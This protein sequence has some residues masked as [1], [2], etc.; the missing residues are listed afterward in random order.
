MRRAEC[1]PL[2]D[3]LAIFFKKNT[4][5]F[6]YIFRKKIENYTY[7][8]EFFKIFASSKAVMDKRYSVSLL[9][10]AGFPSPN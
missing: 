10:T 3:P 1:P 6:V 5:L 9:E 7:V 4:L 2:V 8:E